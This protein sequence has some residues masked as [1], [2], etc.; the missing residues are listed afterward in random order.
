MSIVKKILTKFNGLHYR[1]EYLCLAK[2][3]FQNP[4]HA[5][6]IKDGK[7]IKD[8]TNEHLLTGY[9]PLIFTLTS[10]DLKE[11]FSNIE[12]LFSQQSLQPNDF[13]D[14]RDALARL[15][16]RFIQRQKIHN[17]EIYY[18][19]GV[20]GQ[21]HFISLFHQAIVGL[22]NQIYNRK[23]GNVFLN[24]NLYKQVQIAYSVPRVISL[25]TVSSGGLY[26]LFPT[27]LHGPID[28]QYYVSSLRHGG[29]AC[30][31]VEI[32]GQI[33]I[34]QVH[35]RM[36]KMAYSLGKNHM[37]EVKPKGNFLFSESVSKVFS[38]P[39]PESSL[40][41]YELS[42]LDSFNQGIHKL[43][44]YKIVWNETVD[45]EPSTLAHIHNCYAT[46]RHQRGLPGNYLLR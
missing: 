25:I 13:F 19:E 7:I 5:Y 21:H 16:L 23:K 30:K 38:L 35:S 12:I 43:L 41:Y 46:W 6:F 34:S 11:P 33:L 31:Q 44:L 1:Q 26:N 29:E 18:Y 3:S 37:Q 27:D 24:N 22:N 39:L 40:K 9:S 15:S 10:S 14:T 20:N 2:E 32:A 17:N 28:D 4:I 45:P 8:I 36:Y 42:L